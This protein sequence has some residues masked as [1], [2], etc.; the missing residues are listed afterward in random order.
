MNMALTP[1]MIAWNQRLEEDMKKKKEVIKEYI[2]ESI[3][4]L[5]SELKEQLLDLGENI[6]IAQRKNYVSF[7]AKT[8]FVDIEP[9]PKYL[10]CQ[11]NVKKG[12]LKDMKKITRDVS[13]IGHFGAGDYEVVINS[14]DEIPD[15]MVLVK[16]SY[17]I[18]S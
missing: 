9:H 16:Q 7:K 14:V 4:D 18:N 2:P 6:K 3:A 15:F 1:Q 10:K 5:Y 13:N 11:L 17:E 8:N 12:N